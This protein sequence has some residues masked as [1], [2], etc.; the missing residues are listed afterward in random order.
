[1]ATIG[2]VGCAGGQVVWANLGLDAACNAD[3][4]AAYFLAVQ[5]KVLDAI[6]TRYQRAIVHRLKIP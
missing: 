4:D 6:I 5:S 3:D 1:M 2:S